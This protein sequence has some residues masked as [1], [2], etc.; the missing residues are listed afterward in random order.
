MHQAK[1]DWYQ[2]GG[3][4]R[5]VQFLECQDTNSKYTTWWGGSAGF[6]LQLP[7]IELNSSQI[8]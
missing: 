2:A 1:Y 7:P 5:P 6:D 8:K 3:L 4:L